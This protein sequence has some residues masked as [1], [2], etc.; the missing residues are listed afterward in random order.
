MTGEHQTT[1]NRG[2]Q[3]EGTSNTTQSNPASLGCHLP[4]RSPV[5]RLLAVLRP[6]PRIIIPR[7]LPRALQPAL[8]SILVFLHR[9]ILRGVPPLRV[10]HLHQSAKMLR[11]FWLLLSNERQRRK[12]G[13]VVASIHCHLHCA[14]VLVFVATRSVA[15]Q[16]TDYHN[17]HRRKFQLFHGLEHSRDTVI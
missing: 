5:P 6:Y 16:G 10:Q 2:G 17:P 9:S 8:Q 11:R 3:S 12:S 14:Q 13:C 1:D 15:E 7:T 4:Q